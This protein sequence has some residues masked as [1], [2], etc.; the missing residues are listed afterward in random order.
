[1]II[2]F[3]G[4]PRDFSTAFCWVIETCGQ[5]ASAEVWFSPDDSAVEEFISLEAAHE[6]RKEICRQILKCR[7]SKLINTMSDRL[8]DIRKI[9][10]D[11]RPSDIDDLPR[12]FWQ[13]LLDWWRKHM[14]ATRYNESE[15]C[16]TAGRGDSAEL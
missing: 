4:Q 13:R 16:G 3:A 7:D 12:S 10:H 1:M 15:G 5:G 9:A 11:E 8:D 6:R 14:V 2:N